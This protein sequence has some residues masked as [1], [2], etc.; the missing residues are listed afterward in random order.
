MQKS[1]TNE[2]LFISNRIFL[3]FFFFSQKNAVA[4]SK[5]LE[6]LF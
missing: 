3:D 1:F 4:F 5:Y 2:K 6:F